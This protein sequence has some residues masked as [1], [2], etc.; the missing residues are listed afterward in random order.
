M[1]RKLLYFIRLLLAV[2]V[3]ERIME[4]EEDEQDLH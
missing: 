4:E 2:D 3:Y 1:I